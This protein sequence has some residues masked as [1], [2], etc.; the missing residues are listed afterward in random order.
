MTSLKYLLIFFL[1]IKLNAIL[2]VFSKTWSKY[3][4]F[5]K[6]SIVL[7]FFYLNFNLDLHV[8]EKSNFGF[9]PPD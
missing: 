8:V 7:Y 1:P 5:L 2:H 3:K 9:Y 4:Y 6:Y